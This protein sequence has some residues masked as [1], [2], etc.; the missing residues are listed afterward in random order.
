MLLRLSVLLS[1][2]STAALAG[3]FVDFPPLPGGK[4]DA[5]LEA[6]VSDGKALP[7]R[8]P[9]VDR[10]IP[11]PDT[12]R[13]D[14][15]S[16]DPDQGTPDLPPGA[17]KSWSDWACTTTPGTCNSHC[18][19]TGAAA[20]TVTCNKANCTCSNAAGTAK[21][22]STAGTTCADCQNAFA[23]GCCSGL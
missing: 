16:P 22:C 6:G 19:K 17:C 5:D 11:S 12:R 13:T 9:G 18:P 23:Q 8:G 7:D 10:S 4:T 2:I 14:K 3:C 1:C 15:G 20:L 21:N